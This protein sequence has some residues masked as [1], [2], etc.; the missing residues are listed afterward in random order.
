MNTHNILVRIFLFLWA[1]GAISLVAQAD[2]EAELRSVEGEIAASERDMLALQAQQ[3]ALQSRMEK[4][5]L[6]QC[7]LEIERIALPAVGE[8]EQ[9]IFHSAMALSYNEAHEQA[10][11]VA[12]I[13][14]PDVLE[15]NVSRSNDFRVDSAIASGSAEEADYFLKYPQA[16]GSFEYDG[17]G[18]DRG[19]L[20]PS[21]DFRWSETALSESYFYS[22]MSPQ[23]PEFNRGRWAELEGYLREYLKRNRQTKLYVVTGPILQDDLPKVERSINGLS[24]PEKYFKVVL[25]LEQQRAIAFLMPNHEL[26]YPVE[27]YAVSIDSVEKV[28]GLDFFPALPD[29]L[30]VE[31]ES[32]RTV[33]DWLPEK[34]QED[35]EPIL[36]DDLPRNSYNTVQARFFADRN[37]EVKICGTVVDTRLTQNGHTFLNLDKKFPNHIFTVAIWQS[38]A[39][40]FSY[41]P[42]ELLKNQRVC[43]TG[44]IELSRGVPTMEARTEEDIEIMD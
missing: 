10:N 9:V 14:L 11:W 2:L 42:S 38:N 27:T 23:A 36:P 40:N 43:V 15:G 3:E 4:L 18:Y 41:E 35:A 12:H 29:P 28:S 39:T 44:K 32:Q 31:L 7:Q 13:I 6:T 24:L 20:A 33:Y 30:E 19:H 5:K 26:A 8:G 22:N 34:Q 16:D 37:E 25:D 21:A 17:Y 1:S